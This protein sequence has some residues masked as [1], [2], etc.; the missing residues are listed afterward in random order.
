MINWDLDL[1]NNLYDP[2]NEYCFEE[3]N[4]I[5][6]NIKSL[7]NISAILFFSWI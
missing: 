6:E 4:A 1:D 3:E 7:Y 5:I 2:Y